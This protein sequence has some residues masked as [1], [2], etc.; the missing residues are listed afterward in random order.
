MVSY[1]PSLMST[2]SAIKKWSGAN[3]KPDKDLFPHRDRS[4]I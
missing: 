2:V 3:G 1:L 4:V